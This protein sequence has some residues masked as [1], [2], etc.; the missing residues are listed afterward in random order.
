M[1]QDDFNQYNQDDFSNRGPQRA[2][3]MLREIY[4]LIYRDT[5]LVH[6]FRY[7]AMFHP[8]W[9]SVLGVVVCLC[10]SCNRIYVGA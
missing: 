6:P 10:E 7:I 2:H 8:E 3:N 1:L 4:G 9:V 5:F